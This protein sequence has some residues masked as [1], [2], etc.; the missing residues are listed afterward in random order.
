MPPRR[1]FA[2]LRNERL[3]L[4]M[5]AASLVVIT[6]IVAGFAAQQRNLQE[7]YIHAQGNT[8]A[9]LVSRLLSEQAEDQL[10]LAPLLASLQQ[11]GQD[12]SLAYLA[13]V[14]AS[15][16]PLYRLSAPDVSP[17][18]AELPRQPTTWLGQRSIPLAGDHRTVWEF[19]AP[20]FRNGQLRGQVRVGYFEPQLA[21]SVDQI[22]FV[23]TL[24]LAVFLLTPLFYALIKSEIR[25]LKRANEQLD[26]LIRDGTVARCE[27]TAS[28]E[29]GLFMQRFNQF[30]EFSRERMAQLESEQTGLLTSTRLLSY[31]KA[32]IES[33]LQSLPDAVMVLDE[34]GAVSLTNSRVATLLGVDHDA[35]VGQKPAEWYP[36]PEVIAFLARYAGAAAHGRHSDSLEFVPANAPEKVLTLSAYPLFSPRDTGQI[37]GTLVVFR[38]VTAEHLARRSGGEFVAHVAHELKTPLNT[39]AM[40]S[41]ELQGEAGQSDDFRI[42]AANVIHDEAERLAL[43]IN[44]L[45]SISKIETG[46]L[47]VDRQRVKL[48]D[49]L[50]DAFDVIARDRRSV[51]LSFHSDIPREITALSLDKELFRIA[52]NNLL[53]NAVKY[54]RPGGSVTLS[55]EETDTTIRISVRDDGVGIGPEDQERIFDKFYRSSRKEVRERAGHGL[56]LALAREIVQLHH[57]SLTVNSRL[58]EGSEFVIEFSKQTGVL[59]E[60][61]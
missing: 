43:L 35:I 52:I 19:Y 42:E 5:I 51:G 47:S 36:E 55:A 31:S 13:V 32:R 4:A 10:Q 24:A 39:I 22:P 57:G 53:T 21:P 7:A 30:V 48:H 37:L 14:D 15:G 59:K 33:V 25:P 9:R 8:V 38:D 1:L 27:V 60:A 29:L 28:G 58:G 20:L 34:T 49:M 44:N 45:L 41:E 61:V 16:Q 26:R 3:G 12:D 11:I 40:Y 46:S 56:G 50:K 2:S 17:P 6:L 54:S 23:A 18:P